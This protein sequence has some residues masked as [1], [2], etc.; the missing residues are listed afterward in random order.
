ML[1]LVLNRE[2]LA[3]LPLPDEGQ[4]HVL[5]G[6]LNVV[7]A[8]R[9]LPYF[10]RRMAD[11]VRMARVAERHGISRLEDPAAEIPIASVVTGSLDGWTVH[12]NERVFDY[13]VFMAPSELTTRL[14]DAGEEQREAIA[15]AE[16][17]LRHEIEHMLRPELEE[18]EVLATDV[19]F[20]MDRKELDPTYYRSLCGALESEA[21]GISGPSYLELFER[22]EREEPLEPR[23][24]QLA[25][26]VA[27]A[28]AQLPGDLLRQAAPVMGNHFL[29]EVL[30]RCLEEA[31]EG[32]GSVARRGRRLQAAVRLLAYLLGRSREVGRQTIARLI[33]R[34]G[35]VALMAELEVAPPEGEGTEAVVD[36]VARTVAT[37]AARLEA[38]G[39]VTQ[40]PEPH[41]RLAGEATTGTS[42]KDRIESL[43]A[44]PRVP[45]AVIGLIDRNRGGL[46]GGSS[47]KYTELVETLIAIPWGRLGRI[48]VSPEQFV[49]GLD[50]S[51]YGLARP[52]ELL[53][54]FFTNLIWRYRRFSEKEAASWQ[55]TGSA[56]LFV[57]PPGVG[58]TSLAISA[59]SNLG[60]PF[61][62]VS[63]G[64][65]RD[66]SD[67]R[68]HGFTYEGSKP[69][70]ILQG[71]I[72]MQ[73]MN[74]M[75]ILDEADKTEAFAVA[76]L[77]EI[78]DPEQN[79]LF[80]DKY[81]TTSV[82]IDLSNC[83]FV[84][85]ANTI[86]TVPAPVADRCEIV[87][88]DRYG[89]EEKIAIAERY[90]IPRVRERYDV[91]EDQ[92][93]F[94]PEERE[95][96]LRHIVNTY[97]HEAGVRQLERTLR[98]LFLRLH[99]TQVLAGRGPVVISHD[100][101]KRS[102]EEPTPARTIAAEDRVGEMLALGVNVER[103]IGSVIPIQATRIPGSAAGDRRG[104]LSV[105]HA[106]GNIEKVMDESR[107]VALTAILQSASELGVDPAHLDQP[108]HLHFLG[109]STRK[110]GPSAGG[111]IALALASLL[112]DRAVRRDVAMTGE[113][114]TH[115]RI[116]R[117]GGLDVKLET[118]G[119]AGCTTVIIPTENLYGEQ[120][121]ER[122]P[123]ALQ[124]ELQVL[125]FEEW[126]GEHAPV[127]P[128][129]HL[130]QVVAV[131]HIVQAAEV[132]F[133]DEAEIDRLE[134]LAAAHGRGAALE[135][136]ARK[137]RGCL[138][139]VYV[140]EAGEIDPTF[141]GGVFCEQCEGCRLL[142][143]PEAT[144]MLQESGRRF[145]GPSRMVPLKAE[146]GIGEI[147]EELLRK[148]CRDREGAVAT[149][150]GPYFWLRNLGLDDQL[151]E[152]L[153]LVAS[154]YTAQGIKLKGLKPRLTRAACHLIRLSSKT[155]AACPFAT[156]RDGILLADI[157]FIP[158][159]Y[160]LDTARAEAILG[161]CLS[162]WLAEIESV[163]EEQ[164]P[165]TRP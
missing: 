57:G 32:E 45:E 28:A 11:A 15:L 94:P 104:P 19:V 115:G 23:L 102:L 150:V 136:V 152:R 110:D 89:V 18:S 131:D 88:L 67:L 56:F 130:L 79:H 71:L 87:Y 154:N 139:L 51:H 21:S 83:H 65:M 84:L 107:T 116:T 81:I 14:A 4:V 143:L 141:P 163:A 90:L 58:K 127:D 55:R 36:A 72:R 46:H 52:K 147:I 135:L 63:L 2:K 24:D 140:K 78:L 38:E 76:T 142:T 69:G 159:K 54:D 122:F 5:A 95:E 106:T 164:R 43:R 118:A 133:I 50:A 156:V 3:G 129:Q 86:E 82:D 12:L 148:D 125:T 151:R 114:D 75:F 61:H 157:G 145:E 101:I 119:E 92:I 10:K 162:R 37:T 22:V 39:A 91:A 137:D 105:I 85:T 108:I 74:G 13:L 29:A 77:L 47:A 121:V 44:D 42:L 160:R 68:G 40:K 149:L 96:L 7:I 153:R 49:S 80:H 73:V 100:V 8:R 27:M 70:A 97:T 144:S 126:R 59:A 62:K 161:R 128:K 60:I 16:F 35:G 53:A 64:G 132:A 17:L 33:E 1:P 112:S 103:G 111:A 26:G 113:I 34:Y 98:T 31:L 124:R 30:G 123:E 9:V 6:L 66:E 25:S 134:N 158:E 41:P 117:I 165:T 99:R 120:G 93:D 138:Q 20:A 48:D 155:L 109:A 146:E